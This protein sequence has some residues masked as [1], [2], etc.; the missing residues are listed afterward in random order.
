MA[1]KT[2]QIENCS[3]CGEEC[4]LGINAVMEHGKVVCD[5]CASVKRGFAGLLLPEEKAALRETLKRDLETTQD[6][7]LAEFMRAALEDANS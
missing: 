1:G 6:P 4:V 2:E 7:R 3:K 5:D